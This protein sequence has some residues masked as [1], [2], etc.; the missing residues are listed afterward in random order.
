MSNPLLEPWDTPFE[1]PPFK[2]IKPEHYLPAFKSAF[3]EQ[4]K[5]IE[6]IAANPE[7]PTFANTVE[8]IETSG[9]LLN[10]IAPAFFV[11][12]ASNSN[13]ALRDIQSE[14]VPLHSQHMSKIYSHPG[15]FARL[16]VLK[17]HPDPSLTGEQQQLLNETHKQMVRQGAALSP[18]DAKR[19]QEIDSRLASLQTLFGQNVLM[20]SNDFEL[21]L[22]ES[23][24]AGLPESVRAA[25]ASEAATRNQ[26]GL[27][28]F[29]I[30]RSSFTPFMQ[31]SERRDLR[32]KMW[33]AYT[34]CSNRDNERD[35]KQHA[36]EIA[37]LRAERASMMG[38]GTHADFTL[39]DRMAETPARVKELLD[40][41]WLPAKARVIEEAAALQE[42]I[43]SAGGNHTL[44]PWDWW[45][46]TEK[47]RARRFNLDAESVKP[48]FELERVR[49]GAFQVATQLYGITFTEVTDIELY[50]PAAKA[51]EV[52]EA[53][54]DRVGLFI[55][56]YFLRPSKKAG[57]WMNAFRSQKRHGG[58]AYP[59]IL[60]TCNFPPGEPCL[61]SMDEVRTLF[62]EFGHGLHGLLSNV[63]YRSLSGTAVKRDFVEL[64]SQIMEHWAIEPEVMRSYAMHYE[65]GEVIPDELIQK[66]LETQTFNMGFSTTEYLAASYLDLQWHDL[67][68]QAVKDDQKLDSEQLESEAMRKIELVPEI[69]PRYRSTYFQHIFSGGYSAGYYAYIWAEVLDADAFEEFKQQGLFDQATATSFRKNILEKGGTVE[70]MELYRRFKGR[71]PDV[72]PLMKNRGL[73]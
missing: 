11:I 9:P 51:F 43:Q 72:Q 36:E 24:L 15:L 8:A 39:D 21:V 30:S 34:P 40:N 41:I 57:A 65:T 55:T 50:H 52:K 1:L 19:I 58:D 38:Y 53:N 37:R 7:P 26:E 13:D 70:P 56:D 10:R 18:T 14:V 27:F 31:Y 3:E 45:Y 62:H 54:G 42:S 61:L 25:A 16:Q 73:A 63:T 35:N 59:I 33:L 20:D 2:N 47:E 48:Y 6:I 29:T 46:F 66:I 12:L 17:N 28:V 23:D 5:A 68:W 60:N 64:P 44:A 71:D 32:E 67:E 49:D 4:M 69:A 22:S